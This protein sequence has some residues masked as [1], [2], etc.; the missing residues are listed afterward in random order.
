MRYYYWAV[1]ALGFTGCTV[2]SFSVLYKGP[3]DLNDQNIIADAVRLQIHASFPFTLYHCDEVC[4]GYLK[5]QGTAA[6]HMI[7]LAY[8]Y[9]S[10][11]IIQGKGKYF[12]N[13]IGVTA[14]LIFKIFASTSYKRIFLSKAVKKKKTGRK[15]KQDKI[16]ICSHEHLLIRFISLTFTYNGIS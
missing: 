5:V 6:K 10:I 13:Y 9:I 8:Q 16:T 14:G 1:G 2:V 4:L 11:G 12:N 3:V 15:K 7:V